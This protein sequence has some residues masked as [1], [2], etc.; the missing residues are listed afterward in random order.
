M[1]NPWVVNIRSGARYDVYIGRGEGCIWGNPY[2]HL[3][4]TLAK[5]KVA[6]RAEA[7]AKFEEYLLNSHEL[8]A[9]LP[10][11]RGKILGCHCK[12]LNCHGDVLA[13]YANG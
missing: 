12:P 4:N 13:R 5:F 7:I 3:G 8:L 9:R 6:T 1:R 11:L 2:S 10:E